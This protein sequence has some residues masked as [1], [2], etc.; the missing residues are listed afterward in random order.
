M[1][2][3]EYYKKNFYKGISLDI[4]GIIFLIFFLNIFITLSS[5]FFY[6][7][8]LLVILNLVFGILD[9][10]KR[11]FFNIILLVL[12]LL[13]FVFILGYFATIIGATISLVYLIVDCVAFFK[14][15]K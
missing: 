14:G 1:R 15:M 4:L 11:I 8:I 10:K 13:L 2:L 3:L 5:I 9:K 7:L 12:A 6:A